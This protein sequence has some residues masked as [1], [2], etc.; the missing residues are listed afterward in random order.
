MKRKTLAT[1]LLLMVGQAVLLVALCLSTINAG[2]AL[3]WN[4]FFNQGRLLDLTG[5][6]NASTK[7]LTATQTFLEKYLDSNGDLLVTSAQVGEQL[8]IKVMG[9]ETKVTN[10]NY[11]GRT[12]LSRAQLFQLLSAKNDAA[13]LGTTTSLRNQITPLYRP[14]GGQRVSVGK[15]SNVDAA[16]YRLIGIT[17]AKEWRQFTRKLS[18][19]SGITVSKLTPATGS[20]N[21]VSRASLLYY[22]VPLLGL[23]VALT[24]VAVSAVLQVLPAAGKLLLLGWSRWDAWWYLIRPLVKVSIVAG[25][26]GAALLLALVQGINLTMVGYM[27]QVFV[28]TLALALACVG[29]GSIVLWLTTPVN[30][31]KQKFNFKGL[32]LAAAALNLVVVGSLAAVSG[33]LSQAQAAVQDN[34]TFL[35]NWRRVA[36]TQLYVSAFDHNSADATAAK[37]KRLYHDKLE[38]KAGAYYA[39]TDYVTPTGSSDSSDR[40]LD[41]QKQAN[42]EF[43]VSP[44]YAQEQMHVKLSAQAKRALAAG[45]RVYLLPQSWSATRKRQMQ[46]YYAGEYAADMKSSSLTAKKVSFYYYN[47]N[48]RYFTWKTDGSSTAANPVIILVTSANMT[49][50]DWSNL[51]TN[52]LNSVLHFKD[53]ATLM[54]LVSAKTVARYGLTSSQF[55]F[56]SVQGYVD[57]L[58]QEVASDTLQTLAEMALIELILIA[59]LVAGMRLY[60]IAHQRQLA[61]QQFLGYSLWARYRLVFVTLLVTGGVV[62]LGCFVLHNQLA[63]LFVLGGCG[64][65]VCGAWLLGALESPR[66]IVRLFKGE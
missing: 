50:Y 33:T 35:N 3:K 49:Y 4:S 19:V 59:V 65:E 13:T 25:G 29:C 39:T 63:A 61:V 21:Y 36:H 14:F 27:L 64:I 26:I 45:Q 16:Q 53:K 46:K 28:L 47:G 18:A 22:I 23:S 52:E 34:L 31:I 32:L 11:L 10:V 44:N 12:L 55:Q 7:Q 58:Q 15:L 38:N 51:T 1:A 5:L 30:A 17:S 41:Y 57:G 2:Y 8:Q 62:S 56:E 48:H 60:A 43:T 9:A 20:V 42:W 6:T 40:Y 54:R 66:T 37:I 24:L